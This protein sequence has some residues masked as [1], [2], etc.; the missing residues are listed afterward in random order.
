MSI[1]IIITIIIQ[2]HALVEDEELAAIEEEKKWN[3]RVTVDNGDVGHPHT[4]Y[5]EWLHQMFKCY[6]PDKHPNKYR[7]RY[8][9]NTQNARSMQYAYFGMLVNFDSKLYPY[10]FKHWWDSYRY[11][12]KIISKPVR[13][14]VSSTYLNVPPLSWAKNETPKVQTRGNVQD[15]FGNEATFSFVP[16]YFLEPPLSN[17]I[18]YNENN[19]G[20]KNFHELAERVCQHRVA[21]RKNSR[22]DVDKPRSSNIYVNNNTNISSSPPVYNGNRNNINYN[23]VPMLEDPYKDMPRSESAF[24]QFTYNPYPIHTNA[25]SS[26]SSSS[27]S[28]TSIAADSSIS[29]SSATTRVDDPSTFTDYQYM[30]VRFNKVRTNGVIPIVIPYLPANVRNVI[31]ATRC[32]DPIRT[33]RVVEARDKIILTLKILQFQGDDKDGPNYFLQYCEQVCAI[34]FTT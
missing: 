23:I 17:E 18:P 33:G 20:P 15:V 11:K 5:T 10:N 1:V 34:D 7:F 14:I 31:A 3:E 30:G 16:K 19:T 2:N 28:S 22:N 25:F 6:P 12:Y 29:V 4:D 13:T 27:S 21:Y 26:S 32:V 9:I 8:G 24:N